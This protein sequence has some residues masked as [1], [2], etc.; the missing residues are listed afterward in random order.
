MTIYQ[1]CSA[2]P[3][4]Y[5]QWCAWRMSQ[6]QG[7]TWRYP[8]AP[9]YPCHYHH[10]TQA[11]SSSCQESFASAALES[12]A[13]S[14]AAQLPWYSIDIAWV[15]EQLTKL[16]ATRGY[17]VAHLVTQLLNFTGVI[18]KSKSDYG[19]D[20]FFRLADNVKEILTLAYGIIRVWMNIPA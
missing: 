20:W 12:S 2:M 3:L 4:R 15:I 5:C 16:Q 19:N 9:G 8:Y 10:R 14:G 18:E 6:H 13:G 17:Q 1:C 7:T 11:S